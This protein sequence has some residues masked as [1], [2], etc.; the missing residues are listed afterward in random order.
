MVSQSTYYVNYVRTNVHIFMF[1]RGITITNIF[2]VM[3][4]KQF[5]S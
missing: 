3:I 4:T 5:F 2:V 1:T